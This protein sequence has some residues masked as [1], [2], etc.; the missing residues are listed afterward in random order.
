M[1]REGTSAK[2]GFLPPIVK[3][4]VTADVCTLPRVLFMNADEHSMSQELFD[5]ELSPEIT[6]MLQFELFCL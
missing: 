3:P 5:F 6:V 4:G 2:K 1:K